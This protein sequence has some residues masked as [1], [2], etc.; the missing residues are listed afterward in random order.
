M[1]FQSQYHSWTIPEVGEE[2]DAWGDLLNNIFEELDTEVIEKGQRADRPTAGVS[3]RWYLVT[4]DATPTLEYDN[5][6]QWVSITSGQLGASGEYI[7]LG[8]SGGGAPAVS[9]TSTTFTTAFS[10]NDDLGVVPSAK[11]VPAGISSYAVSLTGTAKNDTSGETTNVRLYD[12][13]NSTAVEGSTAS[14]SSTTHQPFHTAI[15]NYNPG[16]NWVFNV[17]VSVSGGTGEIS[18]NPSVILWGEIQ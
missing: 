13:T 6:T 9:K 5:G 11:N 2:E 10:S 16:N 14:V 8:S 17:E 12:Q 3:G 4:D 18:G 1:T 15:T 7:Q